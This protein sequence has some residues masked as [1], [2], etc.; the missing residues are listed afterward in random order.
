MQVSS[1][2]TDM[3][4]KKTLLFERVSFALLGEKIDVDMAVPGM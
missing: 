3:N 2:D 1:F 4:R